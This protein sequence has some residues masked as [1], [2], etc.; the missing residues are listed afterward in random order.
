[1][2]HIRTAAVA[3]LLQYNVANKNKDAPTDKAMSHHRS[4]GSTIA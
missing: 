1:M 2:I 3:Y 4:Y